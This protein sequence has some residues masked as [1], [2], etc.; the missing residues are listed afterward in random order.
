MGDGGESVERGSVRR[1]LA[2][3]GIIAA[4]ISAAFAILKTRSEIKKLKVRAR[5]DAMTGLFNRDTAIEEITTFL[6][7]EGRA[8][9]HA[10]MVIDLDNF[11]D[12]NDSFGHFEGDK[13]LRVLAGKIRAVFRSGDI[14]GRLGGD[15]FVVLMKDAATHGDIRRKAQELL[16]ALEY[17]TSGGDISVTVT[18][19]IGIADYNGDGKAFDLLYREAD[20]AL[21]RAKHTG[22]NRYCFY[23]ENAQDDQ[24]GGAGSVLTVTSAGIELKAL[25]DNI[26]GGIALL[27]IGQEIRSIYLSSSYVRMMHMSYEGIKQADNR[28]LKFIDPED[29]PA[30]EA[31]LREGA[32]T[33]RPAESVFRRRTRSGAIKWHH[34]RAVRIAYKYSDSPV[35]IAIVTDVTNLKEAE[36][37]YEAQKKQLETVLRVSHVVTFEVDIPNRS[38]Y[39]TEP[40]LAKYGVDTHVIKDMPDFLIDNGIV[41]PDSVDECRRM[42]EEIYAGVEEGSAIIRTL[43]KSGG[44]IVERYTYFTVKDDAGKTVKAV[45][46]IEGME[47]DHEKTLRVAQLEKQFRLHSDSMLSVVKVSLSGDAFELLKADPT[48]EAYAEKCRSYS[49]LLDSVLEQV[50]DSADRAHLRKTFSLEGMQRSYENNEIHLDHEFCIRGDR[51]RS[52]S[53]GLYKNELDGK[54]YAFIR[55]RDVTRKRALERETGIALKRSEPSVF[56]TPETV[57]NLGE[58]VINNNRGKSR[59]AVALLVLTNYDK[60][61]YKYGRSLMDKL[62]LGFVGKTMMKLKPEYLSA[63]DGRGAITIFIPDAEP[64]TAPAALMER[65]LVFLRD[66]AFF[67]FGEEAYMDF[68]T[69]VSVS[70]ETT[71]SF[72]AL[73]KEAENALQAEK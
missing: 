18:G 23:Q 20:E 30:V 46:V 34:M 51:W 50:E 29:I 64:P 9:S 59:C 15:E 27:E 4:A 55:L 52:V 57:R 35:M 63:Y 53:A 33:G 22:K 41:H 19:S 2:A 44:Y 7:N 42:Y 31:M 8:R 5:T 65:L 60:M 21:Y 26:D 48:H 70:D 61:L 32:V 40:T 43:T 1:Y 14:V 36:L 45:G 28:I 38:L 56:Y 13:V 69:A 3:Q 12:V 47:T 58:A 72:D 73:Y 25:I 17:M 11:K 37:K 67:Q 66:P 24:G 68:K 6:K 62:L 49:E 16:N 39:I 71:R 10:L 54:V